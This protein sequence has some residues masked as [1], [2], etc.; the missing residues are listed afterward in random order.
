M[1]YSTL[2]TEHPPIFVG[3]YVDDFCFFSTS[4]AVKDE[5]CRR[6][7]QQYTV[8][9]ENQLEWF[10]GMQFVWRFHPDGY[11]QCHIH[12]EAFIMDILDQLQLLNC[13]TST[14][15]MPFRSGFPVD[16]IPPS[17]LETSAQVVVT[18]QYQ[19]LVLG[20]L[21]W[22][23]ISTRPDLTSILT[24]LS[25]YT[26]KPS[27][28]HLDSARFVAKYLSSTRTVGLYYTSNTSEHL[29]AYVHF[30]RNRDSL[31][32]ICDANWGPMDASV[33]KPDSIPL[34]QNF[35]A[36]R[37]VSG[38][39]A[40]YNGYPIAW[41]CVRHKDT[42]QSSCQAEIHAMNETTKLLLELKLLFRNLG[43]PL[44][45]AIPITNDN[46]GAVQWSKGT[47]TKKLRWIDLHE[48]LVRENV[49]ND[50]ISVSH[51]LGRA[52]V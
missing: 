32:A 49:L 36:L 38:W 45:R 22:L 21:N 40:F 39:L 4:D 23:S 43:R 18:K 33:P 17:Q 30:P 5:F 52:N 44:D 35:S 25:E 51:I 42:A 34:E 29:N 19:Q 7:N 24:L 47:T 31:A 3:L 20:D 11:L 1:F 12:Q 16:T 2:L 15:A 48:N 9:Y 10:L 6:L 50:T 46:Q 37:S 41:G 28:Q 27:P 13:N 8:S 14:R 26:H